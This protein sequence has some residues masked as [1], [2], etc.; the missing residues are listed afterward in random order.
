MT[1]Q[2]EVMVSHS[3]HVFIMEAENVLELPVVGSSTT[4]KV[5]GKTNSKITKVGIPVRV[6]TDTPH[7][8]DPNQKS[9]L[10]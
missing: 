3:Q 7:S 9:L 8:K 5:C 10:E 4:C 6:A 2:V 1:V